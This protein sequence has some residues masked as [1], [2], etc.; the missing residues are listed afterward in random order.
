MHQSELRVRCAFQPGEVMQVVAR[1]LLL[2]CCVTWGLAVAGPRAHAQGNPGVAVSNEFDA[3]AAERARR[4]QSPLA[5]PE[6]GGS[7][8]DAPGAPLFRLTHVVLKGAH[9]IPVRVLAKAYASHIGRSVS[10]ADLTRI[11]EAITAQ[12]KAEGHVADVAIEGLGGDWFIARDILD[13]ITQ[14]RPLRIATLERQMLL[15]SDLPGIQIKDAAVKE[16]RTGSGQFRLTVTAQFFRTIASVDMDNR[17]S[18]TVGPWQSFNTVA[19]NSL[20]RRGDTL[21]VNGATVANDPRQ[22]G[23]IGTIYE[24]PVGANGARLGLR[25]TFSEGWPAGLQRTVDTRTR[26]QDYMLYGSMLPWRSRETTVKLTAGVGMRGVEEVSRLGQ[27]YEDH[28]SALSGAVDV[29]HQDRFSGTTV[30]SVSA[31]QG[32]TAFGASGSEDMTTSRPGA[33]SAFTRLSA[34]AVR[35][36]ALTGP[37]SLML[38]TAGQITSGPVVRSEAFGFGGSFMGRAFAPATFI[39]DD[40]LAGLAELRFDQTF[41][42]RPFKGTQLYVFVDRGVLW[43][44]DGSDTVTAG[45]WGGGVRFLLDHDM[46]LGLEVAT[47]YDAPAYV[48]RE[49]RFLVSFGRTFKGCATLTCE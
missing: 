24:M 19:L 46:R 35:Y 2:F 27:H 26:T 29:V 39:G 42:A 6:F 13:P 4:R 9:S 40:G 15:L 31:R 21:I 17:G 11:A 41:D 47:V 37:F 44:R 1:S 34:I 18:R 45:S 28:V 8:T 33:D 36:Q 14:E 48:E 5:L 30:L 10:Q 22:L 43:T 38:A 25:Q 3:K 23:Y 49:T 7:G 20:L 16:I 32:I 12:Y